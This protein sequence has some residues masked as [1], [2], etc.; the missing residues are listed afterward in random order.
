[1]H[2]NQASS[3][4]QTGAPTQFRNTQMT[5]SGTLDDPTI[6]SSLFDWSDF[7]EFNLDEEQLNISFDDPLLHPPE[8][9]TEPAAPLILPSSEDSPQ[10]QEAD[11]DTDTGRVR[12]R[13]PRMACSNFLAGRIPCACP[14]LDEKMEE[15]ELGGIGPGKKRART[16][17]ASS[18]A[19]GSR[20]QV[21][22]CEADIS[23]LKGYHKRHRVCLRCANATAVFLDGQSKRY[24]QQ[25]GK[26]HILS[27][28]DE[29][30]RSCRRKLERHNNRRRRKA[31]DSSKM[32]VEKESRQVRTADDISG[33]D[34]NVKDSTCTGSQLGEREILLES[35]GHVPIGSTQGIQNNQSD[36]FTAS[37][38]TQGDA[39]KENSKNS[40]SPSYYDN[41]S[42]FSSMCP[43]GRISFKLYDWNPAEF[44]RRLRH[45]I[46][47]WLASM[48]VELEGYIRPGCTILTVF[49]AM[50]TFKW[51]KLLEDPAAHLYEFIASPGNMLRG[52]GSFL[53]YLNNMVFRVTTGE[54]SVV[55]VKLKG[56]A[57]KLKSIH[58][59]CFEAGKPMEFFACGSN[60]MQPRFRF[61]VSF[62]GR[63]L[64]NDIS[65]TPSC[66][67]NEGGSGS[68]EHQLLKIHVPRTE[69]DLFGPAFV[70]VENESGLSNFIPIL[71]AEKDI[72]AEME[73]I[74]R[75]FCSGGSEHTAVCSPC[76]DSTCRKSEFSEFMLDVAW[77]LREPSSENVQIVASVQMQ[78]FNYLLNVLMES[79]STII[80]KRVLPYFENMVNKNLLA[81][82]TDAEMRL[83]QRN[84]Y[85]KNNLLKERL[86]LKEYCAGDAGQIMQE[87]NTSTEIFQNHMKSVFPVNNE[88]VE[89]PHEHNLEFGSAYWESTSTVPLLDAEL[90]LRVKEQSG[91]PCGF[92]VRKTVLTSRTLVFVITGFAVCLG[93]CA[94]FLHPRKVGEFA[95][96][97]RRCLFDNS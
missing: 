82:I 10:S 17:R 26:F 48:P 7:L 73:E 2:N 74:Q 13:D 72:C 22:D 49:V 54:N 31:T 15:E 89:V 47:Q 5:L 34:D 90:A 35:E 21:P 28:F 84:I 37:G 61:L 14:E 59:T 97:I 50:P 36:S 60:L 67:K 58:P 66:S 86:Q 42:A 6:S 80:L 91:K 55:K 81:G 87:A 71:I 29:G 11:A 20:C 88:D 83:F 23:E 41:K 68:M 51:G 52:R 27:D 65:V 75:K 43:T 76:E 64:G 25:C 53:V 24:C 33:D 8:T 45:Q 38:E 44:P 95:M 94:T 4:S 57:P 40:L 18:G 70:E 78:R 92:L 85:E 12:K 9:E 56:P 19:A 69:A 93:L 63:Y 96:T 77:L 32:S 46:F 16:L 79:Q 30:K 1:M 3:P 62:G 39:E